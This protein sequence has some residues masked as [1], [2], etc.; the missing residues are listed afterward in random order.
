MKKEI[1]AVAIETNE[2]D[3]LLGKEIVDRDVG[4]EIVERLEREEVVRKKREKE[5][6][7]GG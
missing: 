6:K 4:R 7:M 5:A 3:E 2:H 1:K